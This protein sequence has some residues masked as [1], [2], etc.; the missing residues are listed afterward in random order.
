M[1]IQKETLHKIHSLGKFSNSMAEAILQPHK[2]LQVEK[3]RQCISR[4]HMQ[5]KTNMM[6]KL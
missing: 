2:K 6:K 4:P 3:K 5:T 1:W